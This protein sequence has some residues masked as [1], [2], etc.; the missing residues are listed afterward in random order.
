MQVYLSYACRLLSNN[1]MWIFNIQILSS[2]STQQVL[3]IITKLRKTL[4]LLTKF[5]YHFIHHNTAKWA[6]PRSPKPVR[7]C[8]TRHSVA[9]RRFTVIE[10]GDETSFGSGFRLFFEPT[11][12]RNRHKWIFSH[13]FLHFPLFLFSFSFFS[14][15][16]FSSSPPLLSWR[17]APCSNRLYFMW[18]WRT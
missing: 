10:T 11:S 12:F 1:K 16:K 14:S 13:F 5:L 4:K 8:P 7:R 15:E 9:R 2:S 6:V 17:V 18:K 3:I